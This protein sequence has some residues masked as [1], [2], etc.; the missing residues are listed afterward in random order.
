MSNLASRNLFRHQAIENKKQHALGDILLLPKFAHSF[1]VGCLITWVCTVIFWLFSSSYTRKESVSG[2]LE[3]P[4]GIVRVY[5]ETNGTIKKIYV[6]EGTTVEAGQQLFLVETEAQLSTG[7]QLSTQLIKEYSSQQKL[8]EE[9]LIR[10]KSIYAKRQQDGT[11]KIFAAQQEL[12]M[13]EQQLKTNDA[14]YN[15]VLTQGQR[16]RSLKREGHVSNAEFEKSIQ[17]ELSLKSDQQ[18]LLKNKI[19]QRNLIE[20][21]QTQQKLLPEEQANAE[22]QIRSRLSDIAQQIAQ[23]NGQSTRVIKAARA[24]IVNNMQIREGQQIS[25]GNNAPLLTLLPH[26]ERL[27]ANLLV[28]VRSAG[29]VATGQAINIRYDAFPYQKFGLYEGTIESISKTILLPNELLNTP[30]EIREPVYRIT[31]ILNQMNVQAYGKNFHLKPGMTLSADIRLSDRTL[32]QW[33]LEPIYSLK[34]RI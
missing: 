31:A 28:P 21:L 33:L 8:L 10:T 11:Q 32:I 15:V 24:G 14:L 12:G 18:T 29:F 23:V 2:W 34:G 7:Q 9:E 26:D 17:Q 22:S 1:I 25:L 13:L 30:L 20:Q 19:T 5:P 3:P 4:A 6:S 27:T 16:L